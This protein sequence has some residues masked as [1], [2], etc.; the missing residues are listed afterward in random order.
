MAVVV[1][2]ALIVGAV[3]IWVQ[4][5]SSRSTAEVNWID[6]PVGAAFL[7]AQLPKPLPA[8]APQRGA[9]P[10]TAA[11]LTALPA[12]PLQMMSDSGISLT[13]RNHGTAPCLLR[14]DP[15]LVASSPGEAN[16][17]AKLD[18]VPD[19]GEV[20]DTAPG[21]SVFVWVESPDYC[22]KYPGGAPSSLPAYQRVTVSIPSGGTLSV[23]G[24][25]LPAGCGLDT[26]AFFTM[27]P[28]PSYAPN[29]LTS[30]VPRLRLPASVHA[31]TS[32]S[33]VV[34]VEN[35]TAHAIRL[36]PCPGYIESSNLPIKLEFRLNCRTVRN[37][38]PHAQ[39]TYQMEMAIPR[40]A[41][42]G[43]LDVAWNLLGPFMA[44]AHGTV[45]IVK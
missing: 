15:R 34:A 30:L 9:P 14:G 35:P 28:Q 31:G 42:T 22:P 23:G 7:K 43:R 33:Y 25:H 40:S 12:A 10:C 13:I 19:F 38:P 2:L 37:I 18:P 5:D 17:D 4:V 27:K 20:T 26:P 16:V 8:P 24:L 39:V 21:A 11:N 36:T 6:H 45:R 41:G 32:L 3:L 1:T 44:A 29:P